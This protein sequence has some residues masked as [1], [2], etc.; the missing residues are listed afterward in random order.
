ME[1]LGI[2]KIKHFLKTVSNCQMDYWE[3]G[4]YWL[5]IQSFNEQTAIINIYTF[6]VK[7]EM[8]TF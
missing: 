2:I 8:N 1:A 6:T 7:I 4:E 3:V 5:I